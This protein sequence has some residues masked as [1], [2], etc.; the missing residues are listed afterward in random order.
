MISVYKSVH[1]WRHVPSIYELQQAA[2]PEIDVR[3][4]TFEDNASLDAYFK[5]TGI[6]FFTNGKDPA[7]SYGLNN[8]NSFFLRTEYKY[9]VTA[10]NELHHYPIELPDPADYI[11]I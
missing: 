8:N 11:L 3:C 6:R 5:L 4:T 1:L 7:L 2:D 9:Y 10:D